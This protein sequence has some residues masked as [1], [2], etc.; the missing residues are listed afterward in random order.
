M[1]HDG[2]AEY[3]GTE[4]DRVDSNPSPMTTPPR[5]VWVTPHDNG[6]QVIREGANRAS[7]VLPTQAE[8]F[9]RGREI[10]RHDRTELYLQD[11]RGRI[12]ERNTYGYDPESSKG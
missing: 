3:L 9:E 2:V 6:W 10:A 5:P 4:L 12:R 8:A 7:T 11:R 1:S